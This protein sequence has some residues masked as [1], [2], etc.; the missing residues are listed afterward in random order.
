M[1]NRWHVGKRYVFERGRPA[2][3]SLALPSVGLV[4]G[5]DF[6]DP[7][8]R[9][10]LHGVQDPTA[11]SQLQDSGLVSLLRVWH[12]T[13]IAGTGG[14][15][16]FLRSFCED[17]FPRSSQRWRDILLFPR[18]RLCDLAVWD[19]SI[20]ISVA[21]SLLE[22]VCVRLNFLFFGGDECPVPTTSTALHRSVFRRIQG[23]LSNMFIELEGKNVV[24]G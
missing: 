3:L 10:C 2:A 15:S 4:M 11:D 8:V 18:P 14:L 9:D 19:P 7:W 6:V 24:H 13:I 16:V 17:R 12:S 21:C 23:K 1:C 22:I 5:R 20:E